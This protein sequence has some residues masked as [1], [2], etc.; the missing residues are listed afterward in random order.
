MHLH[1]LVKDQIFARNVIKHLLNG[2]SL[3]NP[4]EASLISTET[5]KHSGLVGYRRSLACYHLGVEKQEANQLVL[6]QYISC[7]LLPSE[8]KEEAPT[9]RLTLEL[10]KEWRYTGQNNDGAERVG[11]I[12]NTGETYILTQY[13]QPSRLCYGAR[14]SRSSG[15]RRLAA[16]VQDRASSVRWSLHPVA[17]SQPQG[18][19][20]HPQTEA[21]TP[22]QVS[23]AHWSHLC[24][25][26]AKHLLVP[27]SKMWSFF[28]S[29]CNVAGNRISLDC[30]TDKTSNLE[31]SLWFQENVKDVFQ[32]FLTLCSNYIVN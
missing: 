17:A 22:V 24:S 28:F 18:K 16:D 27:A 29:F 7:L 30:R 9:D 8:Q 21:G 15:G 19:L 12:N 2:G 20:H 14:R 10:L 11:E 32:Y 3:A 1:K 13:H 4:T 23:L 5:H 31:T 6:E 26:N 25:K